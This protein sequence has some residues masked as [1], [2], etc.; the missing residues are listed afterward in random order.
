[1]I[2]LQDFFENDQRVAHYRSGP[3]KTEGA[4]V[5]YWMQNAQRGRENAALNAAIAL[6]NA[7]D[8]P[9]LVLF[10]LT[11]YPAANLRHYTFLL[12]GLEETARDLRSR[13]TPLIL[14]TGPSAEQ[15]LLAV[16]QLK[17][18]ALLG[19]EGHTRLPR[20]WR[21]EI[22]Q[23]LKIPF[24]C[25]DADVLIPT[26]H[27]LKEEWA[28]RTIRPKIHRLLSTYLQPIND[29][30][31][32]HPLKEPP[33]DPG[34]VQNPFEALQRCHI[35][36]RIAPSTLFKGGRSE[37]ENRLQHFLHERLADYPTKRNHPELI[38]TSELSAYLHFGQCSIQ[39]I[40][41]EVE[42]FVLSVPQEQRAALDVGRAAFLEEIIVRR[43]LAINF[44]LRNPHY[45]TLEGCP[46]WGQSTIQ[47]HR[48]DLRE[49]NYSYETLEQ[50][51]THDE[52]W[53]ACQREMTTTGRM[54]NYMRMYWA[55]KILEWT[56]EPEQAFAH[57]VSLN[58]TYELDGRDANGY[59]GISW[60][61][62]GRH[63]RPWGPERPIFGLVRTMSEQGLKRKFDTQAYIDSIAS[64]S[65]Q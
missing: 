62:G 53:N 9:V 22:A 6:G 28:A 16:E 7:L 63:D 40:A 2:E 34:P 54:H 42:Q 20:Q 13:G 30:E 5:L 57:A 64:L 38:G 65:S 1:M 10:V 48:Q 37:A 32:K 19:D 12:Q 47:K 60:S 52:I 43:E 26:S 15:V 3:C 39:H 61:M 33:C 44:A 25:V 24:A 14:R 18:V 21:T 45:D 59:T 4:C 56:E 17:A 27:F 36:R 11:E 29:L 8:L 41:W 58:D 49:W 51:E 50:A 35:D 23:K 31:S 46:N 55:K